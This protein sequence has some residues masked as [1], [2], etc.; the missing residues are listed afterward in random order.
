MDIEQNQT[1]VT[2]S[3]SAREI[4]MEIDQQQQS[5]IKETKKKKCH[6]NQKLH[7]F[8]RKCRSR[9]MTEEQ[10]VELINTRNNNNNQIKQQQQHNKKNMQKKQ[11]NKRKRS[12]RNTEID[13]TTFK[14]MSQLSLSQQQPLPKK[15]KTN[16]KEENNMPSINHNL[17]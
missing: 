13:N 3:Q 12:Q 1:M 15:L 8:K 2:S 11:L 7:H 17:K 16:A 9:G 5:K 4:P 14:S 10:I 6:G